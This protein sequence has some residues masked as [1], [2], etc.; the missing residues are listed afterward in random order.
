VKLLICAVTH[1]VLMISA[2][3]R[4]AAM[5]S[6]GQIAYACKQRSSTSHALCYAMSN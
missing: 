6:D 5:L 2:K 3:T 1:C 4:A